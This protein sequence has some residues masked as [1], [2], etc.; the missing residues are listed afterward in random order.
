[1]GGETATRQA[2]ANI[3]APVK[4]MWKYGVLGED[5]LQVV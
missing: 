2:G 3:I 4:S 1:M 5:T